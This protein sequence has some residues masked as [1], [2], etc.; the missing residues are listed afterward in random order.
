MGTYVSGVPATVSAQFL[1]DGV[2]TDP[3]LPVTF[4]VE[5]T[6]G[7][8]VILMTTGVTHTG[9]GAFSY[10]WTPPEVTATTDYLLRWDGAGVLDIPAAEV[11]TVL[12]GV[13]GSWA[14]VAQVLAVTGIERT[15]AA[16]ALAS[17]IIE[18]YSGAQVDMP[19][20]AISV[21]DRHHL[22]RATAW[23]AAWLTSAR[24]ASLTTERE[25]AQSISADN[26]RIERNTM[27]ETV[28]APLAIREL[29][30]LSWVGTRTIRALPRTTR[31]SAWDS[32][33]FLSEASDPP[34][35]GG[36]L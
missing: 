30:S 19:E 35:M 32:I 3:V 13:A 21:K 17:S 29:K 31:A 26:V 12:P 25:G 6:G 18:T 27:A 33:N 23:Q 24:V 34:W 36:P 2:L 1:A 28:L 11:V 8:G 7:G 4:T 5:A 20:V 10:A 16:V 15:A 14:S 9:A 22:M